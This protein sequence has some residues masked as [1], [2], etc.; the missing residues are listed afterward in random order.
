M[1]ENENDLKV[2]HMRFVRGNFGRRGRPGCGGPGQRPAEG[3]QFTGN[4]NY[5]NGDE[6]ALTVKDLLRQKT[7]SLGNNCVI[8]RWDNSSGTIKDLRPGQKVTI[9]YRDVHGVLAADRV[10]Q[11]A[12]RYHGTVKFIDPARNQLVL[13]EWDGEKSFRLAEDCKVVLHNRENGPLAS[14]QRGDH[15]TVVYE[16]PSGPDVVREIAQTS[17]SFTGSVVA[18]DVPHRTISVHGTFGVKPFNLVN[19]CSIV[20]D[21]K[22]DAKLMNLRPGQRLTINYDEVNGVNLANRIGPVEDTR[23]SM[24]AQP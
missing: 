8:T 15:V 18:I 1:Y 6:R 12:L 19:D 7:F 22:T 9:G 13:R 5:V 21:G 14:I 23:A 16:T 3:K 11:N 10:D 4:V 17:A 20:M 24:A 2:V